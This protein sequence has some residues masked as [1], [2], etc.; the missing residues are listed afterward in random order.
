[1]YVLTI[2]IR[3]IE[4]AVALA[5]AADEFLIEPLKNMCALYIEKLVKVDQVWNVLNA[6]SHRPELSE[7][8]KKV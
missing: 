1:V 3:K 8:C 4:D 7:K 2:G 6:I 5:L